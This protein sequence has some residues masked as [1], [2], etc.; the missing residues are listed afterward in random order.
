MELQGGAETKRRRRGRSPD[1]SGMVGSC[2][3]ALLPQGSMEHP[4]RGETSVGL[5]IGNAGERGW[6]WGQTEGR[7]A[8]TVD[9]GMEL[10]WQ[11]FE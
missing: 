3:S 7:P 2:G 1:D 8:L 6:S 9:Q 4:R 5:V 10:A 11:G